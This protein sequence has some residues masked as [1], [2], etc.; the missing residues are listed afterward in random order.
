MKTVTMMAAL[1]AFFYCLVC[2]GFGIKRS[3]INDL[4]NFLHMLLYKK[5]LSPKT[6]P[7]ESNLPTQIN[8]FVLAWIK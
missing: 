4:C 8:S 3:L 7:E 2:M 5:Y 1:A 6:V